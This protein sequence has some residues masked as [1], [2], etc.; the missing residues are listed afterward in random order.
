M[1]LLYYIYFIEIRKKILKKMFK[2]ILTVLAL[3]SASENKTKK[4]RYTGIY[5]YTDIYRYQ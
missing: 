3:A 5:Q 2:V 4:S 1:I